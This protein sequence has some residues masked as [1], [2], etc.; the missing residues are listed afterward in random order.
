LNLFLGQDLGGVFHLEHDSLSTL[1]IQTIDDS[2]IIRLF[3]NPCRDKITLELFQPISEPSYAHIYDYEGRLLKSVLIC[4]GK[5]EIDTE[6]L[7]K[8]LYIVKTDMS[9]IHKRFIKM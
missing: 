6:G 9:I 4:F 8:G 7:R 3:P 5:N 2:E 1:S